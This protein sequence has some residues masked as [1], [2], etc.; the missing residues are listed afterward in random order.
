MYGGRRALQA[1]SNI[2]FSNGNYDPW[3][4]FGVLESVSETVVS[5][6]IDGGG[7]H[8]DLMFSHP[9]DPPSV[10]RARDIE[11]QNM[12]NWVRNRADQ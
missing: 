10:Q 6:M 5:V 3:S 8:L 7:H 2:V 4:G 1:A 9:L 12:W 11:I